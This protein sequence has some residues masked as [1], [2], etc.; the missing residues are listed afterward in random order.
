MWPLLMNRREFQIYSQFLSSFSIFVPFNSGGSVVVIV[1][2]MVSFVR[3]ELKRRRKIKTLARGQLMMIIYLSFHCR[4]REKNQFVLFVNYSNTLRIEYF[5][6]PWTSYYSHQHNNSDFIFKF[7]FIPLLLL[8]SD[9]SQWNAEKERE[10]CDLCK[11]I[12]DDEENSRA[13]NS[14]HNKLNWKN[15]SFPSHRTR[16]LYCLLCRETKKRA[17]HS[18]T[19]TNG[20]I[21]LCIS[22]IH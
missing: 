4:Q 16:T 10:R 11:Y 9:G 7:S 8:R 15:L 22:R 5:A 2:A 14:V 6:Y 17:R 3:R 19:E 12:D 21:K 13:D 18:P 20:T 1:V